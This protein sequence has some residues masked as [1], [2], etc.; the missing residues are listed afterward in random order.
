MFFG[1]LFFNFLEKGA[2]EKR[3]I[4]ETFQIILNYS[5]FYLGH[6]VYTITNIHPNASIN[7]ISTF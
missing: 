2:N 6:I 7:E 5:F 1:T 3:L 4:R